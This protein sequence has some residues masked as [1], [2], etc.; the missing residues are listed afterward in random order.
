MA[1]VAVTP[2]S[3]PSPTLDDTSKLTKAGTAAILE[4][5][6][7]NSRRVAELD[8]SKLTITRNLNPKNVPVANSPEVWS[9]SCTT[10]HML[11][12]R[13]TEK[14]GWEAP[15]IRPYGPLSIMPTASVLHYATECF[16]GMKAYR[17]V[18]GKVRL[19]RADRNARRFLQSATR[20][21]LPSFPPEEFVKLL[22]KFVGVEASKWIAEP[23]S[24]IY[25]RPTMIATAPAL[26]VQR[27]KEALMYIIMVMFP[28]L[29]DPSCKPPSSVPAQPTARDTTGNQSESKHTASK[30]MRLLASRH[31]MIRAWPGGFGNA[32]V[33]A[34]YGPSLVAQGEAR[35]RGYD[36]ILWLFGNECFVTEAG[37]SNFF[38]LW[39]NKQTGRRELVTAPL[40]D[41]VILEG[42]T[43]ASVLELVR[44]GAIGGG[45]VDV[46]E[47]K[48]TMHELIEAQ[49][50][51]RLLEAFGA[52]TAFFIS[53]VQDIHFRGSDLVLPLGREGQENGVDVE[54]N[55][56][57][58]AMA[59]KQALK[60]IMYGRREHEWGVVIEEEKERRAF[61]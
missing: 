31:D 46:V 1:P 27:P 19:F 37:G 43:R 4:K 60:D 58:F 14:D 61:E 33:G 24:F 57:S 21:A 20:I 39:D 15:E 50:E 34:N 56:A 32:K 38:V 49:N 8:A 30:G 12:A 18:D 52:G 42:V 55:G 13:W 47:R 40:E 7:S 35:A 3:P 6:A 48:F 45:N 23:E 16:E 53:P 10:D 51:G 17:G 2:V 28:S 54:T 44:S 5:T 26:G 36:Q 41:G 59:V 22:K 9:Q 11:T 29:D 25:I